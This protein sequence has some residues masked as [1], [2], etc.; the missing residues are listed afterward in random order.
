MPEH[1]SVVLDPAARAIADATANPPYAYDLGPAGYRERMA[2][3]QSGDEGKPDVE[4]VDRTVPV[5]GPGPSRPLPVRIVRP[6]DAVGDL[7]VILHLHGGGWISGS[8]LTHD[9]LIRELAV[10][11]PAAVVFP[12]YSLSPE[13]KY[14]MA[15]HECHEI[16]AWIAREGR[17]HGLDGRRIA[18]SGDSAGGNLAAALT[19]F[20]RRRG[21]PRFVYQAL[22]YPVLDTNFDTGSYR[23]FAEGHFL[24]RDVMRWYWEQYLDHAEQCAEIT[25]APLRAA[26]ADLAGLPPA[27]VITAEADVLRDEGEAYA[28]ALRAAGVPVTAVRYQ[29]TIHAFMMFNDLFDS[30]ATRA[31]V[32]QAAAACRAAFAVD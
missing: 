1:E 11:T 10:R 8:T 20:A 21:G 22:F 6:R 19:L 7:P 23:A 17:A 26:A 3:I 13:A 31:A 24:R 2:A 27:L 28:R 25:A 18:V 9:R 32:E 30:A 16:A 15:L 12:S 4:I 14:P 5:G 29:G